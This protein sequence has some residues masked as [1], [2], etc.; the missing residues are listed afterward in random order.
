M[1]RKKKEKTQ[2]KRARLEKGRT[3]GCN[4]QLNKL[5]K[6]Q[7]PDSNYDYLLVSEAESDYYDEWVEIKDRI[8]TPP[9]V[10]P[11]EDDSNES[12]DEP[13]ESSDKPDESKTPA[14]RKRKARASASLEPGA[15]AQE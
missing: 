7:H 5:V 13:D 10:D 9:E 15:Q 12:S 3:P 4:F 2:I 8:S 6:V 1:P 14:K 11:V